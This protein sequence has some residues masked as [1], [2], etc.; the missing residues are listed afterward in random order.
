VPDVEDAAPPSTEEAAPP[1][2]R[3][4]RAA[5][6]TQLFRSAKASNE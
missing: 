2:R 4:L 1:T 3:R 6:F 5:A